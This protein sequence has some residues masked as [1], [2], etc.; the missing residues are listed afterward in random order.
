MAPLSTRR[1]RRSRE[2][3]SAVP[4]VAA[5]LVVV[6][7]ALA[8]LAVV[9][10]SLAGAARAD[11]TA[12]LVALAGADGGPG[13]ATDVARANGASVASLRAS[14]AVTVAVLERGGHQAVAAA[15]LEAFDAAASRATP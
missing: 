8:A 9:A 6:V 12:D 15:A 7:A 3:A 2:R 5:A 4:L 10:D 1:R 11:A 13:A 14:G